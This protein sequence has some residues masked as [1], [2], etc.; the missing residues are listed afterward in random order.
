MREAL[1]KCPEPMWCV[2]HQISRKGYRADIC[3]HDLN[4]ISRR[5][6]RNVN[7]DSHVAYSSGHDMHERQTIR[8]VTV[9]QKKCPR[10]EDK[11]T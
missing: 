1:I 3:I 5:S 9:T 7:E 2:L 8:A 6:F 4:G 10:S 11:E